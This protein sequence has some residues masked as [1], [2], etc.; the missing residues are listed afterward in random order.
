M[1]RIDVTD[2]FS[3]HDHRRKLKLLKDSGD[4]RILEHRGGISCPACGETFD[5]LF[6]TEQSTTSFETPPDR[7]FCLARTDEKLLLITH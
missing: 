7:P 4:T 3:I 1:E 6:V 5:R 2:G